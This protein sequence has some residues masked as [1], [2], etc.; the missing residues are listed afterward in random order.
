M[1]SSP[2][3]P[4]VGGAILRRWMQRANVQQKIRLLPTVA[5][6]SLLVVL[7]LTVSLG[8]LGERRLARVQR[9]AFPALR[10]GVSLRAR[11]ASVDHAL[12]AA[13][14]SRDALHVAEA[15]SLSRAFTD[16][17]G[18][19]AAEAD[20]AR[21][22]ADF[23]A[24]YA[25]SRASAVIA[26]GRGDARDAR[27]AAADAESR[28]AA[29]VRTLDAGMARDERTIAETFAGATLLE[30]ATWLLVALATLASI[31]LLGA[32]SIVM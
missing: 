1:S 8:L 15:D 21:L 28:Y 10:A 23:A 16:A 30:R 13:V 26:L 22:R 2:A 3:E 6:A 5:A 14:E 20:R 32:L 4:S 7:L 11:L 31:A 17:V 24:Y 12:R 29:V 19:T 18:T 25:A 27:A 9:G